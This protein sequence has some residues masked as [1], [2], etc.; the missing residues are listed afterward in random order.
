LPWV[1]AQTRWNSCATP[2]VG[3][4]LA[5]KVGSHH[6]ELV[7]VLAEL[8]PRDVVGLS[9]DPPIRGC[10]RCFPDAVSARSADARK[11]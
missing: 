3:G 6:R 1:A 2:E 5:V 7:V 11:E 4:G 10:G 9:L 8:H